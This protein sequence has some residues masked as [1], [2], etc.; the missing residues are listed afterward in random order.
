MRLKHG[1][2]WLVA[3]ALASVPAFAGVPVI[4]IAQWDAAND[5][6]TA[7]SGVSIPLGA[8]V[9]LPDAHTY[10]VQWS[11]ADG[12]ANPAAFNVA[13]PYDISTTHT[14]TACGVAPCITLAIAVNATVTVTDS[15]DSAHPSATANYPVIM[16][17]NNLNS[18]VNIA[19]DKGLWYLHTVMWRNNTNPNN[20]NPSTLPWGGWDSGLG[21]GSCGG[22]GNACLPAA[23]I[24]AENCQAFLVKGHLENGP[25][26][27]SY[28]EDAQRCVRRVF[29]FMSSFAVSAKSYTYNPALTATRCS[30]G[31]LPTGYGGALQTC[32]VSTTLINE[33]PSA[34]SC[35]SPPCSFTFDTN[36]NMQSIML[37]SFD[38]YG[39]PGYQNGMLEDLVVATQNPT[40][41]TAT[42]A[43][44]IIGHTYLSIAQDIQD[45][46][47]FCQWTADA[48]SGAGNNNGGGWGYNCQNVNYDD[49]SVSQ[50]DAI[51]MIGGE[52]GFGIPIPPV[53]TDAN[54]VWLTWDQDWVNATTKGQFGYNGV[55]SLAWGP[56]ATTPSGMVQMVLDGV[57]RT[58]AGATDQ[59]WNMAESYYADNFCNT[60]TSAQ[61]SPKQYVYGMYSF[62]KAMRLHSPGG[63]LSPITVVADQP[64]G[65]THV[66]DWYNAQLANGDPCDGFAQT[67]VTRQN[68]DGHWYGNDFESPQFNFDTAWSILILSPSVFV[69]CVSDLG[70][71]GTAGGRAPARVD[72]TWTP[73]TNVDHYNVL[74]GTANGGPYSLIGS[75]TTPAYSDRSG[76]SDKNTFYYVLQPIAVGG[77]SA[78]CQSNQAAI[79]VP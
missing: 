61:V 50:W 14:Y 5:A 30:N 12:S 73:M 46:I 9:V 11:F 40:A 78:V 42:G 6:H 34:T 33:N 52:R 29:Y 64:A 72:L 65:T 55:D 58:A 1:M 77:T 26:G 10:S 31:S 70:G 19:I 38:A 27:D 8:T 66:I 4:K 22:G 74:R 54:Q 63:I 48:G 32:P 49:N 16:E 17:V 7:I 62:S 24:D 57:G 36:G 23:A 75:S 76:L 18:R 53:V 25:A 28:T 59:R 13:N 35:L 44:G 79:L 39:S 21:A 56:W 43:T 15:T 37:A 41:T 3:I 51:G 69:S 60:N 47:G 71:K 67:L 2:L 20:T 68:A 45:T